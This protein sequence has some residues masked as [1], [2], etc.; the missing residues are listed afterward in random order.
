MRDALF[1]VFKLRTNAA[2]VNFSFQFE[3]QATEQARIGFLLQNHVLAR[4]AAQTIVQLGKPLRLECARAH[5]L[6][7]DPPF[8]FI[9]QSAIATD[10]AR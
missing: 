2:V 8:G 6:G 1:H 9:E 4:N 10:D 7:V 5:D 3:Q